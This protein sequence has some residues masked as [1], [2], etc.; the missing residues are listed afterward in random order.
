MK[1]L[2]TLKHDGRITFLRDPESLGLLLYE[3]VDLADRNDGE[4]LL[5]DIGSL[6]SDL[7][8]SGSLARLRFFLLTRK[9]VSE[10]EKGKRFYLQEMNRE[11]IRQFFV[12]HQSSFGP[13][14]LNPAEQRLLFQLECA[15]GSEVER[16]LLQVM[17]YIALI[18]LALEHLPQLEARVE[19]KLASAELSQF[20][21]VERVR[22][23]HFQIKKLEAEATVWSNQLGNEM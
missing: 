18:L 17:K 23:L 21:A 14:Q 11:A 19:G 1:S 16:T 13:R 9:F 20:I 10:V 5:N 22:W 6:A 8:Y 2:L 7:G 15:N 12:T 4:V 3:I